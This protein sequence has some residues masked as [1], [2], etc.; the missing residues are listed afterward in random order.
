M[1]LCRLVLFRQKMITLFTPENATANMPL[2]VYLHGGSGKSEDN[3]ISKLTENGFC[4]WVS[5][6]KF[7]DVPAYIIFPQLPSKYQGWNPAKGVIKQLVEA[8]SSKY[9]IDTDRISL[10]GHSMGGTG[11]YTIATAYPDLFSCIAPMSGSIECTDAN[12]TAL[13][14][15]PVWAFVGSAD[16]IV[17]PKYSVDF[18]AALQAKGCNAKITNFTDA[19]HFDIPTLAYLDESLDV[20]GWLIGN[21]KKNIISDYADNV[22][23]VNCQLPDTYTIIFADYDDNGKLNNLKCVT[24]TLNYGKNNIPLPNDISIGIND[25]IMLWKSLATVLPVCEVYI[26]N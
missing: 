13:G 5:E 11:T 7:D 3:D 21:S 23:V 6:K 8:V 16:K 2:I 20:V 12:I 10:T 24:Q 19:T 17:D 1:L 25:K 4:Q 26:V 9:S 22:A 14:N 15:M 18:V